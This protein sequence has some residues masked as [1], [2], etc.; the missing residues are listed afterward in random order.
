MY[1]AFYQLSADP[2]RLSPDPGFCFQHRTY[3][4][5]MAY[6]LHALHRAEG[7]IMITGRPGTGKT[8]LIN[9]LIQT[10]KPDQAVVAKI[11]STQLTAED[12]LNLVAYAFNLDPGGGGKAKVL[13]QVKRFLEQQYQHGRRPLLIV[14]EA[15]DMGEEAL[16]EL[17]LLTNLLVGN[18]QLLQVF[19]IGQE[20]LRDTVNTPSLEQLNQRLIAA[21]LLEPLD[22]DDT[23]AYMKHR[24]R[25][26]N[27]TGD[28]LL[29]TETYAMIQRYSQGIPRRINQICSRLFLHG[30]IEEKHRLGLADLKIVVEELQQ[31]LLLPMDKEGSKEPVSWPAEQHEETYEEESYQQEDPQTSP[32]APDP[33]RPPAL[34]REPRATVIPPD[35]EKAVQKPS[36]RTVEKAPRMPARAVDTMLRMPARKPV[37]VARRGPRAGHNY[38]SFHR[39]KSRWQPKLLALVPALG[40]YASKAAVLLRDRIRVMGRPAVWS[41]SGAV[42]VLIT[43]LLTA[44]ISD[45]DMD[46]P[47]PEEATL[48]LNQAGTRQAVQTTRKDSEVPSVQPQA[49]TPAPGEHVATHTRSS[50]IEAGGN[51]RRGEGLIAARERDPITNSL[52]TSQR[53]TG[54]VGNTPAPGPTN[55]EIGE[56]SQPSQDEPTLPQDATPVVA[57][58]ESGKTEQA[59]DPVPVKEITLA[60]PVSKEEKIA[61]FLDH[62]RRTLKRD[63]L[64]FPEN[65]SAYHYFQRVL[66]LDPGN[67]DALHGI[68]QITAR[69]ARLATEAF[70]NNDKDKAERYIARGFRVSPND[71]GLRALRE[72]MN[73]PAVKVASEQPP[74]VVP[75]PE[76]E[77]KP[78]SKGLFKRFKAIFAKQP[79]E[80]I[81][82]QGQTDE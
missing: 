55:D 65:N 53:A 44:Y 39:N 66:K 37:Y 64:L 21:T 27:W 61:E 68:E 31:E 58:S 5:A 22:A 40:S 81:D 7:F 23:R 71:E 43:A 79:N 51:A 54:E 42:L 29:S 11:V 80:K 49:G 34:E 24:L 30:N 18:H 15:Q 46:Q 41:G 75:A 36:T 28:P 59:A 56:Q 33:I 10:L 76:P 70:E 82:N 50:A 77:P 60:P 63:Q 2:F 16:E 78:E 62:G 73:A 17:R 74:P 13:V 4:K 20:Q 8:T 57:L 35:T 9:D 47:V 19:L 3:R 26:V 32:S 52:P 1:E 69:Y 38:A 48:A 67:T 14:D 6:M 12:L 25:C 45:R 72:R